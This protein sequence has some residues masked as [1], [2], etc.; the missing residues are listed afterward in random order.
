M[1]Q[2]HY[3]LE[4]HARAPWPGRP[5]IDYE[6]ESPARAVWP[7]GPSR[8]APRTVG[9]PKPALLTSNKLTI[10]TVTDKIKPFN[11][12][13]NNRYGKQAINTQFRRSHQLLVLDTKL[14]YIFE[15]GREGKDRR[16]GKIGKERSHTC[17]YTL[18]LVIRLGAN[19]R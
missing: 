4:A 19:K 16:G 12:Y 3:S 6:D 11:L 7:A 8:A 5:I 17:F 10:V 15:S 18:T 14:L 13:I 1:S 2:T 9:P